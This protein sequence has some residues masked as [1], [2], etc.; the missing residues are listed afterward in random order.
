MESKQDLIRCCNEHNSKKIIRCSE[1]HAFHKDC[2]KAI[3]KG[4]YI[5]FYLEECEKCIEELL[6]E[7]DCTKVCKNCFTK[8]KN[9]PKA[10]PLSKHFCKKC[11]LEYIKLDHYK[12]CKNCQEKYRDLNLCFICLKMF[13]HCDLLKSSACN[14][15]Y[16]CH[17][18]IK[19][20]NPKNI[21]CNSCKNS[22]E[23]KEIYSKLTCSLCEEN[24]SENSFLCKNGHHFCENCLQNFAY[25]KNH[26]YQCIKM[27]EYLYDSYK[28]HAL[29]NFD[30]GYQSMIATIKRGEVSIPNNCELCKKCLRGKLYHA[31]CCIIHYYCNRCLSKKLSAK[32][33]RKEFPVDCNNCKRYFSM[34]III[35]EATNLVCNLCKLSPGG[36]RAFCDSNHYYCKTCQQ[37]IAKSPRIIYLRFLK[38]QNCVRKINYDRLMIIKQAENKRILE[39]E[40]ITFICQHSFYYKNISQRYKHLLKKFLKSFSSE[41]IVA[42]PRQFV[43]KCLDTTCK[44]YVTIPFALMWDDI[45]NKFSPENQKILENF[46]LYFDGA[47]VTFEICVCERIV[48]KIGSLSLNCLCLKR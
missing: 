8:N 12:K 17:M 46:E 23:T 37:S 30:G 41:N 7:F 20:I 24:V 39:D 34:L 3:N 18:C 19:T 42:M 25:P 36:T 13:L 48:G 9:P 2:L 38:C 10:C 44:E 28:D 22:I 47:L 15:H 4:N 16:F 31:S 1:N 43:I 40:K 27:F 21:D 35:D 29:E 45:S 32:Y 11:L 33:L 14:T 5:Y 26:C 6:P